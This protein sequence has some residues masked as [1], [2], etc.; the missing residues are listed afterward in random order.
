MPRAQFLILPALQ[1]LLTGLGEN[2]RLA[3]LRRRFS[4]SIV[5]ERA[6]MSRTTLRAIERGDAS[7]MIGAY[8][9]VL[10]TLGLEKD[11]ALLAQDDELG[12]K[13]QDLGLPVK[14]RAPRI[15]RAKSHE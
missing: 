10:L 1:R 13:L 5:A 12:R 9:R 11:L 2:I 14:A 15:K 4:A 3:R 6:G 7:V 8:A